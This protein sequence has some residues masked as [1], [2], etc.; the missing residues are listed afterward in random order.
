MVTKHVLK[1]V[2]ASPSDVSQERTIVKQVVDEINRVLRDAEIPIALELWSWETDAQPGMHLRGA[3]GQIDDS[4]GIP[5]SDLL[6]GI[7]WRRFGTPTDDA[8]SG[9]EHEIRAAAA[10]W[11]KGH[12]PQIAVYFR[13]IGEWPSSQSEAQQA[14]KVMDFKAELE[15]Q[16]LVREYSAED[17]FRKAVN[18][19]LYNFALTAWNRKSAK[20]A[21]ASSLSFSI[22]TAPVTIRYEGLTELVSDIV[23][24]CTGGTVPATYSCT[25]FLYLGNTTVTSRMIDKNK[26]ATETILVELDRPDARIAAIGRLSGVNCLLFGPFQVDS[27]G[28]NGMRL[29]RICNLRSAATPLGRDGDLLAHVVMKGGLLRQL[30]YPLAMVRRGLDFQV[31]I[32]D[33]SGRGI[34]EMHQNT[35]YDFQKVATLRFIETFAGA[36]KTR[37]I[38]SIATEPVV[39]RHGK[40]TAQPAESGT[41]QFVLR[42]DHH[43]MEVAGLADHGTRLKAEFRDVPLGVRLFVSVN[44]SGNIGALLVEEASMLRADGGVRDPTT[45]KPVRELS[46]KY[47]HSVGYA[48]AVWEVEDTPVRELGGSVDLGV[49]ACSEVNSAQYSPGFCTATVSGRFD[50]CS[51]CTSSMFAQGPEYP[52]PRFTDWSTAISF[53]RIVR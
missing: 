43:S 52:V 24:T 14:E 31:T 22:A 17:D 3:Q 4:L 50:P 18:Q 15:R 37:T 46:V 38:T 48:S 44:S 41:F 42:P 9:T 6:L 16:A 10:A 53:L 20:E 26:K 29:Y 2:L 5:D 36:F 34:F 39:P 8:C 21:S 51:S 47:S 40:D 12:K 11:K 49:F 23:L 32:E 45:R 25:L 1:I 28:P 27:P 7:F 33:Y 35:R 19:Q 13:H 30:Q